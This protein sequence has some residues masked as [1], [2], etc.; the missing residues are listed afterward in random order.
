MDLL[1]R[2]RDNKEFFAEVVDNYD[3]DHKPFMNT[4]AMLT[5][6][7]D[8]EPKKVIDLGAGTGL[9][10][11]EFFK[12]YPNARVKAIDLTIEMLNKIKEREFADKVDIV[13]DDFFA[14]DF[15]KDNDVIMS[16]SA[17]HHFLYDEKVKLY[18]KIYD[19][20]RE[21]GLFIN[22]DYTASD[23]AEEEQGIYNYIHKVNRH[24]DTPL[25]L[26]HELEIL[27][28]VGFTDIEV[29]QPEKESYKLIKARK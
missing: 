15:G 2:N 9:E 3:E 16:T 24:N 25:T 10:L 6:S 19:A 27:H 14:C 28:S 29:K 8:F 11:I 26:D 23:I 17:L 5:E 1:E 18:K 22:S 12:K 7:I 13:C 4:K 21:G 20:L